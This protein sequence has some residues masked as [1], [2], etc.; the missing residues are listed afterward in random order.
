MLI[1]LKNWGKSVN[2]VNKKKHLNQ[3]RKEYY[4]SSSRQL[5]FLIYLNTW[6]YRHD[7]F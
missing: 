3:M 5:V 1:I 6:Q 7:I 2:S 4:D